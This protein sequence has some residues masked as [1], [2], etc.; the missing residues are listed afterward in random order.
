MSFARR[1]WTLMR[2]RERC[3]TQMPALPGTRIRLNR[4]TEFLDTKVCQLTEIHAFMN[5]VN[6]CAHAFKALVVELYR[7]FRSGRHGTSR[8]NSQD[9]LISLQDSRLL[10]IWRKLFACKHW[11]IYEL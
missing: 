2:T 8:R 11:D 3:D 5:A 1:G 4:T 10:Q 9:R 6:C 7:M